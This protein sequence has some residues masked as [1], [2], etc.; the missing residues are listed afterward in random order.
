MNVFNTI[1]I[2][3]GVGVAMGNAH[4]SV[5]DIAGNLY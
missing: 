2:N 4:Q 5:K 3:L 1:V